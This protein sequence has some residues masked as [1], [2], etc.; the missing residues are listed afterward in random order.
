MLLEE[1]Q[2]TSAPRLPK[3]K[4]GLGNE[5][6]FPL[7]A[8]SEPALITVARQLW[9][10]L[11]THPTTALGDLAYSLQSRRDGLDCRLAIVAQSVEQLKT[12][13]AQWIKD[14]NLPYAKDE[15]VI[16]HQGDIYQ[17]SE[18]MAFLL[19][20]TSKPWWCSAWSTTAI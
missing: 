3:V 20:A 18:A 7:S 17:Q 8:L 5:Y 2:A 9:H 16:R 15:F 1:Y 14:P 10:Y 19:S 4:T 12:G 13:L 11:D 6:V